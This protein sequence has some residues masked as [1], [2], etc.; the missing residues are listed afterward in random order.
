MGDELLIQSCFVV[1]AVQAENR[2]MACLFLAESLI[3]LLCHARTKHLAQL[4]A[5]PC[6]QDETAQWIQRALQALQE[7]ASHPVNLDFAKA[8]AAP[9]ASRQLA[10]AWQAFKAAISRGSAP[11]GGPHTAAQTTGA[12]PASA[13]PPAAGANASTAEVKKLPEAGTAGKQPQPSD[14]AEDEE[15]FS[16]CRHSCLLSFQC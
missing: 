10:Q 15:V 11:L 6:L 5:W 14:E 3:C 9:V 4:V 13:L 7:I 16:S 12:I 8:A 1:L 2:H